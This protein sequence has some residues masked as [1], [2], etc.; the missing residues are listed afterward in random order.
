MTHLVY[1]IQGPYI[2]IH[3]FHRMGVIYLDDTTILALVFFLFPSFKKGL[4][5]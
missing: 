4:L 5:G 2:L 1:F 3:I